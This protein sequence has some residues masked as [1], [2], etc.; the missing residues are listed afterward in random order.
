MKN[1][2]RQLTYYSLILLLWSCK[3]TVNTPPAESDAV[4]HE[5]T[6]TEMIDRGKYLVTIGLCNDCHSPKVFTENGPEP[7]SDRLLSGHP[8][9]LPIEGFDQS[10]VTGGWV[11]MNEH[12]T[13]FAGP[14]GVSFSG[15]LTPD[16]SGIGSWN[17]ENF[18]TA[19]RQGKFKGLAHNRD[20][21]PPMPWTNYREL[22]DQDIS[23][24]FAYLKSLKPV[25]NVVPA[26]R[27]FASTG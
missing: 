20:L 9:D 12:F 26:P 18:R 21:L 13:A 16:P 10:L 24:I 25:K 4:L 19:L 8:S 2:L 17:E 15:N 23:A 27:T 11:L 6:A 14:W 7:D 5:T 1:N 22:N 3:P